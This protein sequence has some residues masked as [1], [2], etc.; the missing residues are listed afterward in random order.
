ERLR[1]GK[2]YVPEQAR[3]AIDAY[4]SQTNLTALRELAMQTAAAQVDA[5]LAH[6]YR[7]RGEAAPTLRGRLLVGVDGDEQAE[8]LVRHASR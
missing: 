1:E 7:L 8:R 6:G 2:V 4:F 5:D 3:A